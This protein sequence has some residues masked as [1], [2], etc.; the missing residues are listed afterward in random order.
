[1]RDLAAIAA[2]FDANTSLL[3]RT[4]A[5]AV[6]AV[7]APDLNDDDRR[8]FREHVYNRTLNL[9]E[10]SHRWR[11]DLE[12]NRSLDFLYIF[13]Q[14]WLKAFLKDEQG[15]RERHPDLPCPA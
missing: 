5:D 6:M 7:E 15:Y 3:P 14:H 12:S 11:Q 4:V 8:W 9:Y 13:V 10:I 2:D 1:M